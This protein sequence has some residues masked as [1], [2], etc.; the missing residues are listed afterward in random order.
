MGNW[1]NE[2]NLLELQIAGNKMQIM[3]E[4]PHSSSRRSNE[5][6][7]ALLLVYTVQP[8]LKRGT[9]CAA[10]CPCCLSKL[11]MIFHL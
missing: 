1:K 4:I 9:E 10:I 8:E 5:H 6:N 7:D 2:N 11:T 3:V